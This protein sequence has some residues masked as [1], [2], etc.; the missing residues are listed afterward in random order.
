MDGG[1]W[2]DGWIK[3]MFK[4]SRQATEVPMDGFWG[5]WVSE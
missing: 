3:K 5:G 4:A 1:L 2:V